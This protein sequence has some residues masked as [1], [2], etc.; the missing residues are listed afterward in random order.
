M[1]TY[2]GVASLAAV[3]NAFFPPR[4]HATISATW[5]SEYKTRILA[6]LVKTVSAENESSFPPT[7]RHIEQPVET[8][9]RN[10]VLPHIT[11]HDLAR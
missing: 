10:P 4:H 11:F 8:A 7:P 9:Q 2:W 6:P 5:E 3:M 1:K